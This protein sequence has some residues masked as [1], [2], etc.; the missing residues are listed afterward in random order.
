VPQGIHLGMGRGMG[1]IGGKPDVERGP[2]RLG[3][4]GRGQAGDP[5]RG[6]L[7]DRVVALAALRV[8]LFGAGHAASPG[9]RAPC[10]AMR[11]PVL[12]INEAPIS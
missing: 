6:F 7:K 8:G 5:A 11:S 3:G 1:R 9:S 10:P 12:E 4:V 2:I